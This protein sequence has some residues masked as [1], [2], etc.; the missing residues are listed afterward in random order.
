[1]HVED[2]ACWALSFRQYL[3]NPIEIQLF[4]FPP[5]PVVWGRQRSSEGSLTA[6]GCYTSCSVWRKHCGTAD[7]KQNRRDVS[8]CVLFPC[9]INLN[10]RQCQHTEQA[11]TIIHSLAVV[12]LTCRLSLAGL[13]WEAHKAARSLFLS[14]V[15][16][17]RALLS[18]VFH[19]PLKVTFG[20]SDLHYVTPAKYIQQA[21]H[22]E[23][24]QI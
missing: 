15:D 11:L 19:G 13:K 23:P 6:E 5:L 18:Q 2:C 21:S 17:N 20:Q 10:Q 16:G 7:A 12:F 3:Q 4:F 14:Q 8:E 1:M 9:W 24:F 22:Y